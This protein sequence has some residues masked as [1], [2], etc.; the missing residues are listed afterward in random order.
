MRKASKITSNCQYKSEMKEG[1]EL[2]FGA[3]A[4]TAANPHD[5]VDKCISFITSFHGDGDTVLVGVGVDAVGLRGVCN[6]FEDVS[7]ASQPTLGL[8][9]DICW[10]II[11]GLEEIGR[12]DAGC[13]FPD[14]NLRVLS[15]RL[16]HLY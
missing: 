3:P 2:T 1:K 11:S 12:S 14:D 10:W 13:Q 6:L 7:R 9:S 8:H 15:T 5:G 16:K 4:T